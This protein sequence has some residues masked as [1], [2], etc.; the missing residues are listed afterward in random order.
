MTS[1][2]YSLGISDLPK[3]SNFTTYYLVKSK[4]INIRVAKK[5][6]LPRNP[7]EITVFKITISFGEPNF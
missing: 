1:D 6:Y 2:R 4:Q 7:P 3:Y 5:I